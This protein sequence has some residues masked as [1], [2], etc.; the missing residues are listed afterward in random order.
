MIDSEMMDVKNNQILSCIYIV[1]M[2]VAFLERLGDVYVSR[3]VGIVIG[4]FW[5]LVALGR[6]L[7]NHFKLRNLGRN[8]LSWMIKSYLVPQIVL[9]FWTVILMVFGVLSWT[10]LRSNLTVYVPIMLAFSAICIFKEKAYRYTL[11]ALIASYFIS[12]AI[13]TVVIGPSIFV[14]AIEEGWFGKTI[15]KTNYLEIHDTV[16]SIGFIITYYLFGIKKLTKKNIIFII[17]ALLI[18][19]LGVKRITVLAVILS[20]FFHAIINIFSEKRQIKICFIA[21]IIAFLICYLFVYLLIKGDWLW[22]QIVAAGINTR[23]RFY[24]WNALASLCKFSPSFLGLGRAYSYI[25]FSTEWSYMKVG[26][27]HCDIL[28]MYAENGFVLFGYW[29]WHFLIRMPK[30]YIKNYSMNSAI[31]Y[32]GTTI[33]LFMMYFTDNVETYFAS[34]IFSIMIPVCHALAHDRLLNP[35]KKDIV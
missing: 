29:L 34:I 27:A 23:G 18:M 2:T 30:R 16:L 17:A 25:L 1:S 21:G 10:N 9:H 32:F 12:V 4:F 7:R 8:D 26:A 22:A 35:Q 28:K 11:L 33:Y 24:Y 13:S 6:L 3:N 14:N 15:S 20:V 31:V 5:I 19:I